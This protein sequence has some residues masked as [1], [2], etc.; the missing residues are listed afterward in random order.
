LLL[1]KVIKKTKIL[2]Y[3]KQILTSYNKTRT[4]WNIVKSKT[5]GKKEGKKKYHY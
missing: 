4:T 3:K 5:G 1:L 2:Q